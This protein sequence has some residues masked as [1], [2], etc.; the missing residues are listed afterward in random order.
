MSPRFP[1][2]RNRL[3]R[4]A[5]ACAVSAL[6]TSA[7]FAQDG[8]PRTPSGKPDFSG[9]YDIATLTPLTRPREFGDRLFL[10]K[11]EADAIVKAQQDRVA[12]GAAPSDPDREAPPEG[13]APPVGLDDSFLTAFGAG[14]TG[15]YNNF[16]VDQGE[17][18]F[19]IDGKFRTSIIEDPKNGQFP[20]FKPAGI[21]SIRKAVE[22]YAR[23]NDGTAFWMDWPGPGPYD[24][25]ESLSYADRCLLAFGSSA[26]PPMLP[27][28]YNNHKRLVLTDDHLMIL[29]EMVHDVRVVRIDDE[30]DPDDIRRWLGDAVAHWEGDTLVIETRNFRDETGMFGGTRTLEVTEKFSFL[31][32][33]DLLYEFTVNDPNAWQ[34]PWSGSYAWPRSPNKVYEYACHEGNY[35]MGG[36]LRGARVLE[37]DA[38]KAK[39]DGESDD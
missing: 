32:D 3:A 39:E 23:P 36:I 38:M 7:L 8:V 2:D 19:E 34:A 18:V 14:N 12:L 31:N 29:N 17:A 26:G 35:A 25:P 37:K 4:L 24:D 33:S 15:G 10:T 13:G 22:D 21:A 6:L 27:S 9:T 1:F 5:S 20:G 30:H 16:W 11:D 28:L